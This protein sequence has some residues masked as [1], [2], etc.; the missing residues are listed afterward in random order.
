[1]GRRRKQT[2]DLWDVGEGSPLITRI[3][4]RCDARRPLLFTGP[5]IAAVILLGG[6]LR[7]PQNG[8]RFH[9]VRPLQGRFDFFGPGTGGLADST[10]GYP[11]ATLAGCGGDGCQ[12]RYFGS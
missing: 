4:R 6:I 1:M 2:G 7:C 3:C 11:L 9:A 8:D 10:P 12:V 5:K